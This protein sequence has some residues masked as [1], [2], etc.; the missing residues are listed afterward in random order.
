M[1][2][3]AWR[4]GVAN[5]TM[6]EWD[7]DRQAYVG[8]PTAAITVATRGCCVDRM[9]YDPPTKPHETCRNGHPLSW[10]DPNDPERGWFDHDDETGGR[11]DECDECIR[12]N[13]P[14]YRGPCTH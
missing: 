2:Y 8:Q 4:R 12:S 10:H 9:M 7:E 6:P 13:G 14:H 3:E 11:E 1:S 5:G